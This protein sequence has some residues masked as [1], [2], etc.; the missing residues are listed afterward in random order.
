MIEAFE[1]RPQVLI[2]D[3]GELAGTTRLEEG[4]RPV[5]PRRGGRNDEGHDLA[6]DE[7]KRAVERAA[8]APCEE[9][10][11]HE[12]ERGQLDGGGESDG[13]ARRRLP[14][15]DSSRAQ[16]VPHDEER[17]H[18]VHL[19]EAN[20][21]EHGIEQQRGKAEHQGETQYG[22]S[23]EIGLEDSQG[24]DE[25]A[26]ERDEVAQRPHALDRVDSGE[27]PLP[28]GKEQGGKGRVREQKAR[29]REPKGVEV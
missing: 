24:E 12:E 20:R 11:G 25:Q 17:H 27:R 23:A 9:K 19:T 3:E 15:P 28:R 4:L 2:A 8:K 6:D 16:Q 7:G 18:Q 21:D 14:S 10:I 26:D 13:D 29:V 5:V 1:R 22:A